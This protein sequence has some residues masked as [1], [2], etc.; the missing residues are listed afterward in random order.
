MNRKQQR[1]VPISILCLI[2]LSSCG[3]SPEAQ[4]TQTALAATEI[5]AGW[6][7]TPRQTHTATVT[8]TPLPTLTSTP[9]LTETPL[10]TGTPEPSG[11]DRYQPR[12][13]TEVIDIINE[14]V[15]LDTREEDVLYL[16]MNSDY[17][18]PSNVQLIYSGEYREVT[19][20]RKMMITSWVGSFASQ[21]T[22]REQEEIFATEVL[23]TEDGA[24]Y[25]IP[26]QKSLIEIMKDELKA[27]DEV[28][29][30]I[31]WMGEIS[32]ADEID[33]VFLLN[34]FK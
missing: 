4:A 28:T 26:V 17:H 2:F 25:W 15:E 22:P 24:E 3:L 16:E 8:D 32:E 13:M 1:I 20:P 23:F 18:Y 5:A 29:V 30:L 9:K 21:L 11:W 10:P 7:E 33:Y 14:E 34:A 12:T 6:T 27:G 31:V 19:D